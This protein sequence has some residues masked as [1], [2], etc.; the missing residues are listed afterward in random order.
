MSPADKSDTTKLRHNKGCFRLVNIKTEDK[1]AS[2]GLTN[3]T[4]EPLL[5]KLA[6]S[7][8]TQWTRNPLLDNLASSG[9]TH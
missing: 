2:S 4:S 5:D 7:G 1:L 3:W 6:S 9:H 8:H